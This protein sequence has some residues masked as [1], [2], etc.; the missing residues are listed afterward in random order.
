MGQQRHRRS[1]KIVDAR[2]QLR[3]GLHLIGWLY[4]YV[5]VVAVAVNLPALKAL[6]LADATE[7]EYVEA[8]LAVRNFSRFVL[9]PLVLTFVAMAGHAVVLT[10]RIAG[11]MY[12]VKVVLRDMAQ[13]RFPERVTFRAKDFL[14]DVAE[15]MTTTTQA[16]R[17][18][19]QRMLRMN[20][21][22]KSALER[23][24]EVANA[25]GSAEELAEIADEALV[26]ASDMER[27]IAAAA[28]VDTETADGGDDAERPAQPSAAVE[29]VG[30]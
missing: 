3:L 22:T 11:P 16:L 8:I 23:L 6:I 30:A 14:Q 19:Q 1:Q 18:D 13:R 28:Q 9:L 26:A 29:P 20:G 7:A 17:E 15:E 10:H 21:E 4:V 27:H 12:R 24:L 25:G 2:F 5:V